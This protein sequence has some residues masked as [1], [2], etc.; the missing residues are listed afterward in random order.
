MRAYTIGGMRLGAMDAA[1]FLALT[2][3]TAVAA[4]AAAIAA[5][6]KKAQDFNL[7]NLSLASDPGYYA[8]ASTDGSSRRVWMIPA[9]VGGVA[10]LGIGAFVVLKRK[11]R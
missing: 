5:A 8:P 10:L 3:T 1:S 4:Q 11:K 6:Q 9:I 2:Q 7:A